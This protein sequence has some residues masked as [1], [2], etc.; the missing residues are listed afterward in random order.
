[1]VSI[2]SHVYI[3]WCKK[4]VRTRNY[5]LAHSAHETIWLLQRETPD[6]IPW[7]NLRPL[8][9]PDLNPVD[10]MVWGVMNQHVYLSRVYT[11]NELKERLIAVCSNFRQ[12]ILDTVEKASLHMCL[13]K[14]WTF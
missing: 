8:N 13:C 14:W 11:V 9:S 7:P 3:Y 2:S 10:Y 1:M 5:A 6:F 12:E 4:A